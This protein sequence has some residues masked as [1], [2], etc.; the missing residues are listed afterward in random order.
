MADGSKQVTGT[1][2]EF[3]VTSCPITTEHIAGKRRIS[4]LFLQVNHDRRDEMIWSW[5]PNG[6]VIHERLLFEFEKQGF[7][8]F[9]T[10][11]AVVRFRDGFTSSEYREFIVTGWA[12]MASPESGIRIIE[13]CP[14]CHRKKYSPVSNPEKLIDWDQWTGD[15]FFVMW[16]RPL[17]SLITERVAQWLLQNKVKSFR[18][19]SI[20]DISPVVARFGFSPGR[21]SDYIPKD[22][23]KLYGSGLGIV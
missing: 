12:G 23:A 16:P 2:A 21:L 14:A 13:E 9:Q 10:K 5:A 1:K 3:E 7:S 18:L 11:P 19:G 15:D 22:L 6:Y 17:F 4:Q 8:G 20:Q